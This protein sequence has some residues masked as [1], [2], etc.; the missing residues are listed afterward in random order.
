MT[1]SVV[2]GDE[3]RG[4]QPHRRRAG[5]QPRRGRDERDEHAEQ[6]GEPEREMEVS[7]RDRADEGADADERALRERRHPADPHGEARPIAA[8]PR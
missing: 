4:P 3:H 5:E 2:D 6:R 8:T 1:S 7:S